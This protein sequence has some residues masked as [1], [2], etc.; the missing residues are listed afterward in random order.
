MIISL[1]NLWSVRDS[2]S[3][4]KVYSF[5]MND[6]TDNNHLLKTVVH[7]NENNLLHYAG[8]LAPM[9][10]LNLVTGAALQMQQEFQWFEVTI[11]LPLRL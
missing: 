11:F 7:K 10:K 4:S 6:V 9:H 2:I 1:L 8:Q 3:C 5:L